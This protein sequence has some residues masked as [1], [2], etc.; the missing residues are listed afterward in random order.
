MRHV[1]AI[2][3]GR[4][5]GRPGPAW[6]PWDLAAV[7][8]AGFTV[9]VSFDCVHTDFD[10]IRAAGFEHKAICVEDFSAPA[11]DQLVEFNEFV[12]RKLAEGKKVLTHCLAGRG[13]TG[14]FLASRLVWHGASV[15]EAVKEVRGKVHATQGTVDG[16]IVPT[17]LEALHLFARV[18]RSRK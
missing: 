7:R 14:T 11:I 17:Q 5:A 8:A 15:E 16:A 12:D 4:V 6:A 1:Y 10:E 3:D 13:R 18:V 9:I 2:E